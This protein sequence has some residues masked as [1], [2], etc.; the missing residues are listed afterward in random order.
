MTSSRPVPELP[1][2]P[3][4]A[5]LVLRIADD[6]N[7][8]SAK[9]GEA[10]GTDPILAMRVLK[11]AN[12]SAYGL[13]A[14][15]ARLDLA[16]SLLGITT[17]RGLTLATAAGP[18]RTPPGFWTQAATSASAAEVLAPRFGVSAADL[19]VLGLLHTFGS[20]LLH[21]SAP[22]PALC[23]QPGVDPGELIEQEREQYGTDHA[24]FGAAL[25]REWQFPA[26][27]C[28]IV[29]DHDTEPDADG[30]LTARALYAARICARA[31]MGGAAPDEEALAAMQ[32]LSAGRITAAD[33][34][35]WLERIEARATALAEA[36]QIP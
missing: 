26:L 15:V 16:V 33:V 23:L 22:V 1:A 25:L 7:A 6:P 32:R 13:S 24:A 30:E 27:L 20:A 2:R 5:L 12:S 4:A 10:I 11:L 18:Q 21:Q 29:A 35:A 36:L 17:V 14:R 19:F 9:L 3:D 34:P 8:S 28:D 31:V